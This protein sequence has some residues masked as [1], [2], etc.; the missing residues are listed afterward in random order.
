MKDQNEKEMEKEL[1]KNQFRPPMDTAE[2]SEHDQ[3]IK[4]LR[5]QKKNA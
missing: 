5:E 1:A 3:H 4:K 2:D